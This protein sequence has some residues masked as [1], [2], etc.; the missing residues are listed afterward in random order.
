MWRTIPAL[1]AVL[2]VLWT[3]LANGEGNP[4]T[5]PTPTT[6]TQPVCDSACQ[7]QRDRAALRRKTSRH[8]IPD[9]VVWCE[10]RG[11]LHAQNAS[12]A[13]GRYQIMPST[14]AANLPKRRAI[15]LAGGDDGPTWSSRLLQ[16]IDAAHVLR[17][18]GLGAWS[19][20]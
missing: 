8:P 2:C 18:Q 15:H 16:D 17:S 7:F 19:C 12:G 20:A 3:T 1:T 10:S 9:Y 4:T 5:Q 11:N 6:T 14:W 13:G